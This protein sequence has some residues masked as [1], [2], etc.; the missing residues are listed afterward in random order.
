[1]YFLH[2]VHLVGNDDTELIITL[3]LEKETAHSIV[4]FLVNFEDV[5]FISRKT[6]L[7]VVNHSYDI[8]AFADKKSVILIKNNLLDLCKAFC[9]FFKSILFDNVFWIVVFNVGHQLVNVVFNLKDSNFKVLFEM[10]NEVLA[11]V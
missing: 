5:W 2:T 6:E 9:S 3:R 11:V 1:M 4:L 8:I 7:T 10:H